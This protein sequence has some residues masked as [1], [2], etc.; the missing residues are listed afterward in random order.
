MAR[1][2][3][4]LN[5]DKKNFSKRPILNDEVLDDKVKDAKIPSNKEEVVEEMINELKVSEDYKI[6][7]KKSKKQ[8][9]DE[10]DAIDLGV[11]PDNYYSAKEKEDE[12]DERGGVF[13][14]A[15]GSY[16]GNMR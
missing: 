14:E 8:K 6:I 16:P 2:K 7:E 1:K 11:H 15:S 12:E 5:I 4:S 3:T 13:E 9:I 10:D